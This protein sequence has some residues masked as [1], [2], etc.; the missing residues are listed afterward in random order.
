MQSQQWM[1]QSMVEECRKVAWILCGQCGEG[2]VHWV[3]FLKPISLSADEILRKTKETEPRDQHCHTQDASSLFFALPTFTAPVASICCSS[4]PSC[5]ALIL[6]CASSSPSVP[7][8]LILISLLSDHLWWNRFS[9]SQ[10]HSATSLITFISSWPSWIS[11]SPWL[12]TVLP[13][14]CT[15]DGTIIDDVA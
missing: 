6:S 10:M 5:L 12:S 9:K 2:S 7:V 11:K 1:P 13:C 8:C 15:L 3:D 14:N 4:F